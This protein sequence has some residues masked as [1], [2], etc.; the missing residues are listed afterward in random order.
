MATIRS[1]RVMMYVDHSKVTK[2][3]S[4]T[5]KKVRD[6]AR[7]IKRGLAVA[8]SAA[9]AG[10]ALSF[11]K[12]VAVAMKR[13]KIEVSMA[14]LG[15]TSK[16]MKD[17]RMMA[18]R[19]SVP[20]DEWLE[21]TNRLLGAGIQV[22]KISSL[23]ESMANLAAGTG[24]SIRELGLVYSQVFSKGR[25]QGEEMLQFMERNVNL[26]P[27]L[28]EVLGKSASE[29]V[30]MQAKGL[31]TPDDVAKAMKAMTSGQG[32]FAGMDM[33]M[34]QT[35][36]GSL[37]RFINKFDEG[38]E[39]VGK[40][41]LPV[42]SYLADSLGQL[43]G[44]G[45]VVNKGLVMMASMLSIISAWVIGVVEMW[46]RFDQITMGIAGTLAVMVGTVAAVAGVIRT[47]SLMFGW[48]WNTIIKRAFWFVKELFGYLMR[49]IGWLVRGLAMILGVT[50]A[51]AAAIIAVIVAVI[52]LIGLLSRQSVDGITESLRK[53]QQK[54]AKEG[55]K[56]AS[57]QKKGTPEA[58]GAG[59]LFGSAE[60]AAIFAG[61]VEDLQIQKEILAT[62]KRIAEIED[63][64]AEGEKAKEEYAL[65]AVQMQKDSGYAFPKYGGW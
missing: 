53:E 8:M 38:M 33:A 19:S 46:N 63:Q 12:A 32:R 37:T 57:M 28:M 39:K 24:N 4:E 2:G 62:L 47:I 3:L 55:T 42:L 5:E 64:L 15:G 6:S 22:E 11:T 21:G 52:A 7:R 10:L 61:N 51:W 9:G 29:I 34:G 26:M 50:N 54:L 36:Q 40:T 20:M 58:T 65:H 13:Q 23:M 60:A 1:L 59:A 14:V 30:D 27:G 48:L 49:S 44:P 56:L 16:L 18:R 41:L 43:V 17:I 31:I 45:G 25:L 35:L